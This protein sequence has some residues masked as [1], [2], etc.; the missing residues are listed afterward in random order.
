[1][2]NMLNKTPAI[3]SAV[4]TIILLVVFAILSLF[5]SML[6]LNGASESK[7]ITAMAISVVCQ[8]VGT[9]LAGVFAWWLTNLTITKFN[10]N[11]VL[12]VVFSV[13][14]GVVIGVGISFLS[15][16][17]SIPIPCIQ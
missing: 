9:I 16:I 11:K 1:M 14:A 3:I 13:I 5:V 10:W 4:S 15:L 12:A 7:G 2:E 6:A 8:G 17:V